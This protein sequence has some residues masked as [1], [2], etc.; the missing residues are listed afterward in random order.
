MS[1][2]DTDNKPDLPLRPFIE[3]V[4]PDLPEESDL[5]AGFKDAEGK[6][7]WHAVPIA[8]K[9]LQRL[10]AGT[11]YRVSMD[12]DGTLQPWPD[13]WDDDGFTAKLEA[14]VLQKAKLDELVEA[15]IDESINEPDIGVDGVLPDFH[16]L[17]NRLKRASSLIEREIE[18]RAA[19]SL[20][21]RSESD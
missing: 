4:D 1:G 3:F 2:D 14:G 21:G 8:R 10:F 11:P 6:I 16:E 15:M 18:R 20:K 7:F 12:S 17:R 5:I 19:R 9:S 13:D